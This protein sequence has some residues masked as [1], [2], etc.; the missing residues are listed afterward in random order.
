MNKILTPSGWKP[1]VEASH[2]VH[3]SSVAAKSKKD[4]FI[5]TDKHGIT[6]DHSTVRHDTMDDAYN[7]WRDHSDEMNQIHEIIGNKHSKIYTFKHYDRR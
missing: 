6:L 3:I 1:I 4:G 2:H 5:V 7:A